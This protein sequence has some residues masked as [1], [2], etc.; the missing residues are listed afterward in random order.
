MSFHSLELYP[1]N[2]ILR[3][4]KFNDQTTCVS[5][6]LVCFARSRFPKLRI[7]GCMD[8][9]LSFLTW[10]EGLMSLLFHVFVCFGKEAIALSWELQYFN[11]SSGLLFCSLCTSRGVAN[12]ESKQ[13]ALLTTKGRNTTNTRGWKMSILS[14]SGQFSRSI[15]LFR[16]RIVKSPSSKS[17]ARKQKTCS[18][19]QSSC[20]SRNPCKLSPFYQLETQR[21]I[22]HLISTCGSLNSTQTNI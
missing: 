15:P 8:R 14:I 4:N 1:E 13:F 6:V 10:D 20:T 16:G 5:T 22:K 19:N 17:E 7:E 18:L 2:M 3:S 21:P 9:L 12:G 11:K